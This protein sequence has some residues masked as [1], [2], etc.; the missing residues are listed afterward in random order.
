M[1]ARL[2]GALAAT[3]GQAQL[4]VPNI[5]HRQAEALGYRDMLQLARQGLL[6]SKLQCRHGWH[7]SSTKVSLAALNRAPQQG[8]ED[9]SG[10]DRTLFPDTHVGAGQCLFD[11]RFHPWQLGDGF[12]S[13]G[14]EHDEQT[15]VS[16]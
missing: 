5:A 16:Q 4:K 6:G 14:E 2:C 10:G 12:V 3:L 11:E 15:V 8:C 9:E 7:A 1:L 13:F